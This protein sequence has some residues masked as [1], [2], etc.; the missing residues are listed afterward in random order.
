MK[1]TVTA[2]LIILSLSLITAGCGLFN[3]TSA[4]PGSDPA[5]GNHQPADPAKPPQ[6][7]VPLIEAQVIRV[8]D[9]DTVKVKIDGR[10]ETVRFIGVNTP[11]TVKPNSPVEPYGKEASNFTK[12]QLTGKSVFLEK[13]AQEK[14]QYGRLLAYLWKEPPN[15]INDLEIRQKMF[16]AQLLLDGFAQVMTIPPNVKYADYFVGYQRWAR[17]NNKGL[18][19]IDP[20]KPAKK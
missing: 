20:G 8:V 19:G 13:D 16:N 18:W 12:G 9:G 4:Q 5:A 1:K 17:E 15:E 6:S 2:F 7:P 11:E 10:E 3:S 14:D